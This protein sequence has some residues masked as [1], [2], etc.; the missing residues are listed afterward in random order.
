MSAL[1]EHMSV[2]KTAIIALDHTPAAVTV[3]MSLT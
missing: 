3:D 1:K 2:L